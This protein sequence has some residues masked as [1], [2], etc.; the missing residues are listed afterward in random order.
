MFIW[1]TMFIKKTHR[2]NYKGTD[3]EAVRECT[4][5]LLTQKPPNKLQGQ[6]PIH[7]YYSDWI[8]YRI[9]RA[10]SSELHYSKYKLDWGWANSSRTHSIIV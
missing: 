1:S 9:I 6:A 2:N 10:A 8:S 7:N 5:I 3:W 4:E